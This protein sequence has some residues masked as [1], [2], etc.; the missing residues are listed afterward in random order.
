MSNTTDCFD[1]NDE[2]TDISSELGGFLED[3]FGT[4]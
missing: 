2:T 3:L 4:K 1:R